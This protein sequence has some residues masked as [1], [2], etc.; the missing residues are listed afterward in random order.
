MRGRCARGEGNVRE[1]EAEEDYGEF[2][3]SGAGKRQGADDK[4]EFEEVVEEED[5]DND[6]DRNWM[7]LGLSQQ[8]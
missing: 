2:S 5:N 4:N 1:E 8:Q 3:S 7:M 6:D